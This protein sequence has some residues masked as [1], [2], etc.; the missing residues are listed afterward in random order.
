MPFLGAS[1]WLGGLSGIHLAGSAGN[2]VA[3]VIAALLGLMLALAWR[4]PALRPLVLSGCLVFVAV[5]ADS[6]FRQQSVSVTPI[7]QFAERGTFVRATAVITS[8]PRLHEGNYADF[9]VVRVRLTEVAGRGEFYRLA[10]PVLV[11]ADASW[12]SVRL[13][14]RVELSGQLGLADDAEVAA[15]LRARGS[16]RVVAEPRGWW[17]F[18]E[19]I[20]SALRASVA[21]RPADQ[22]ALVPALVVGDDA[23]ITKSLSSDFGSTGLTHLLAVSG[24]N[25]TLLVGFLLVS[26]RWCGVR[27]NGLYVVGAIGILGFILLARLEPSVVRA[28]AMGAVGLIG[29]G[30]NGRQRGGRA[31]GAAVVAVLLLEPL[32][33]DSP[34]FA[35]SVLATAGIIYLAP[36]WRDELSLW[37]PRWLAE[38]IAV[39]A[40]AQLVCT[41]LVAAL[42]G[43]VSLVAV[44]ANLLAA[45][46][47]GPATVLGLVGGFAGAI[48]APLG[49]IAGTA[50][51]WCAG[52]IVLV[53]R[54]G[55]DLPT[56]EF[57]WGTSVGRL[58]VLVGLCLMTGF[59]TTWVLR[60][61]H[62]TLAITAVVVA[63]V[64][65]RVPTPGWPPPAWIFAACDV[66]QGDA[67]VLNAGRGAAV[68]I[69]A[70]P[71][72]GL[73]DDCLRRLDV[74]ELPLIV[75]THFHADH[76]DGLSGVLR[77]RR[78]TLIETTRVLAPADRVRTVEELARQHH[79]E[80]QLT[81]YGVTRQI[82]QVRLQ[83]LWPEPENAAAPGQVARP[84]VA[85]P[86]NASV[87]FIA[88][89]DG[90]R[91]LLTGDVEPPAQSAL[92]RLLGEVEVDVLKV[93][94]HGSR[95]Q[96]F[97]FLVG[98]KPQ[99]AVFSAGADNDYGHPAPE[100]L[101]QLT[102]AKAT[103]VR[104]DTSGDV[105]VILE[106][107]ELMVKSRDFTRQQ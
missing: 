32:L 77:G 38:A 101:A 96:D 81:P 51:S 52:W 95:F 87:V 68:V 105:I 44:A 92:A 78:T 29:L 49:T 76:V 27:G 46:A 10:T 18:A 21:Y 107:G 50:A 97:D 48:W 53:A 59:L 88:D 20:R 69:D 63:V 36:V 65:T 1:A 40:A 58:I 54:R 13:G 104:T 85:D 66:G 35:L 2:L 19:R 11:M 71:D 12:A 31:L 24:T 30:A 3:W 89:V 90:V 102:S 62:F 55:A 103:V 74:A 7:T 75:L 94:H 28:A 47:V 80:T 17:Q 86:N 83:S 84:S 9:V 91:L 67:L 33:A 61:W 6:T 41:P 42:S 106:D 79:I 98:L 22:R 99:I 93:P 60:R 8:D 43:Q 34:G 23:G 70:G 25:L 4:R 57:G 64:L 72:P 56:P 16:P 39:P 15:I 5:L 100:T 14:S 73:V 37:L 82:G 26:A 45:P